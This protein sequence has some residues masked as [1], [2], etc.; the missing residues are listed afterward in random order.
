MLILIYMFMA[1][2]E[3]YQFE[4][5]QVHH[6]AKIKWKLLH[7]WLFYKPFNVRDKVCLNGYT[8]FH[9]IINKQ[10][11]STSMIKTNIWEKNKMYLHSP[12]NRFNTYVKVIHIPEIIFFCLIRVYFVNN[13]LFVVVVK[14]QRYVTMQN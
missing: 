3:T 10:V 2:S 1:S 5:V 6:L 12:Y 8:S 7:S 11:T 13:T 9:S 4:N 14:P